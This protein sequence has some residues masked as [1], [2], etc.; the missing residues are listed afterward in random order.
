VVL[1]LAAPVWGSCGSAAGG[2]GPAGGA[3][4]TA[5]QAAAEAATAS[6]WRNVDDFAYQ[7]QNVDLKALGRTRFDVCIIDYS[8]DG[9]EATRFTK[10]QVGALRHSP[11]GTKLVLAYMSIGEA[12]TYRWYWRAS[13]DADKDG[14]PDLGAPAW[15]GP[16]NPEWPDNYKVRYW[17]PSWQRIIFGTPHSYLDKIMAAGFDGVYLDIIDAYEYW[18]PGGESGLNRKAAAGEMVDFVSAIAHYAHVV[19]REPGFAVIPQNG[20]DL[21]V[22]PRYL[23]AVTGIGQEDTWYNGDTTQP[24]GETA[25][26]VAGLLR[27]KRAGKLVL[28]TDYCRRP[29]HIDAFYRKARALGFVPYAT[30]RDLDRLIV[31]AGHAPR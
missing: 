24:A 18:G 17:Y 31:N 13:W 2:Q 14:L 9:H 15:L 10:A 11:G 20:A 30:V 5:A 8:A 25:Y 6:S 22:Y 23:R 4:V 1:A 29:A 28:C 27:F 19:K 7:L 26:T 12:E 21:G 16:S 3:A